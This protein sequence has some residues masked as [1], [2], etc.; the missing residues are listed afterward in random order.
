MKKVL[1]SLL[2][3]SAI[4]EYKIMIRQSSDKVLT[5]MI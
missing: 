3:R 2:K 1:G 4:W 5:K